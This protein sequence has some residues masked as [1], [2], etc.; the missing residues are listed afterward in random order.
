MINE[1]SKTQKELLLKYIGNDFKKC[2]YLY[3]N[4]KKLAFQHE[5]VKVWAD[6]DSMNEIHLLGLSYYDCLHLYSRDNQFCKTELSEKILSKIKPRVMFMPEEMMAALADDLTGT[7]NCNYST[8]MSIDK[9]VEMNTEEVTFAQ[10]EDMGEIAR[11]IT[12][13]KY[14]ANTY[15]KENLEKQM[16]ERFQ[17]GFSRHSIIK[18]DGKIIAHYATLAEADDLAVAG[19]F[20]VDDNY[21]GKGYGK[22]VAAHLFN[23]LVDENKT[24]VLFPINEVSFQLHLGLGHKIN[25]SIAKLIRK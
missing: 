20:V 23:S 12:S 9:K 8:L 2:V 4:L 24:A 25:G 11:L 21:R 15:N 6:I 1:C 13:D 3:L 16:I 7:Y 17:N 5:Q 14:F 22:K 18:K 10:L 19:L